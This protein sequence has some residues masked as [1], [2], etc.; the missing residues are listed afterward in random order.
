MKKTIKQFGAAALL[1]TFFMALV[2]ISSC[3]KEKE[4]EP[5]PTSVMPAR[6]SIDIP[7]S[8]SSDSLQS[9]N[10]VSSNHQLEGD[11]IYKHLRVFIHI[12]EFAAEIMNDIITTLSQV[13]G[14]VTF[15]DTGGDGRPKFY[16]VVEN[17]VDNSGV[18]WEFK[19]DG[20][21]I[22]P[23]S[24]DSSQAV[25]VYWNRN[26]IRGAAIHLYE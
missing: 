2:F 23:I 10:R 20:F 11:D 8:I 6:F 5:Q 18:T 14:A 19:L 26:P 12:G 21:D 13:T 4:K 1:L 25:Q 9:L 15:Q 24:G 3:K 16:K 22:D 7:E 17:W